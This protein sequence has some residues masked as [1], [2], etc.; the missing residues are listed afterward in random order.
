MTMA[1]SAVMTGLMP[2]RGIRTAI[3]S[4]GQAK[5]SILKVMGL[6]Q[7]LAGRGPG[8]STRP[9]NLP[10]CRW[11]VSSALQNSS[12]HAGLLAALKHYGERPLRHSQIGSEPERLRIHV[13][14]GPV[15]TPDLNTA[16]SRPAV[17]SRS[18]LNASCT[19]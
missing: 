11:G 17:R 8:T 14:K 2:N 13:S 5:K 4:T 7:G 3:C 19:P 10:V 18:S 9:A 16:H 1:T 12:V 15:R 6:N